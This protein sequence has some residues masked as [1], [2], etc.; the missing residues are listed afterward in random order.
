MVYQ[1]LIE[2]TGVLLN[3]SSCY[4]HAETFKLLPHS[5]GQ[6]I[7]NLTR[8]PIRLPDIAN[9][10][11]PWEERVLQSDNMQVQVLDHLDKIAERASSRGY[12]R[13]LDVD[14]VAAML[15][16]GE[17]QTSLSS[18]L[19]IIICIVIFICLGFL[20]FGWYIYKTK[21]SPCGKG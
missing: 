18:K 6:T 3:S 17:I 1:A 12:A 4:V 2:G 20:C 11:N 5:S 15:R 21:R 8:T 7:F 10:L 9:I 19:W 13:N 14:K 16:S